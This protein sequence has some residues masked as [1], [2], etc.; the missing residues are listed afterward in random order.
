[1][2]EITSLQHPLVKHLAKLR[3]H[4]PYR[5]KEDAA[6]ITGR[7]LVEE[8]GVHAELKTLII[9]KN[10]LIPSF[11]RAS[12]IVT[13]PHSV[14]KKITGLVNPEPIAAEI[15]APVQGNLNRKRSIL[16]LDG[17]SDPGN[18]GTLIRTALALGWEGVFITS[19]ST[20]PFNEKALR[21]AKGATFRIPIAYGNWEDLEKLI[22]DNHMHVYAANLHGEPCD[23]CSFHT[24]AVLILG[25]ESHGISS[26][27]PKKCSSIRIPIA[28]EMESLNVAIAG[29]ILMHQIKGM[30]S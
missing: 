19:H 26:P 16:A 20:D 5:K 30:T 13:A 1:M 15:A 23:R 25:N 24:P 9:D 18:L 3:T 29:A 2:L 22:E 10:Y 27:L 8:V 28:N 14:F 12:K 21:A 11:I 4:R 17:I 7:K 6:F